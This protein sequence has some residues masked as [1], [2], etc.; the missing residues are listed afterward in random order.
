[1]DCAQPSCR[2]EVWQPCCRDRDERSRLRRRISRASLCRNERCGESVAFVGQLAVI[3]SEGVQEGRVPVIMMPR[4][5]DGFVAEFIR[6]AVD[7][8]GLEPAAGDPL[9]EAEATPIP[10][11]T[12]RKACVPGSL[13][14]PRPRA[15]R[16]SP[17]A[18][19]P[20]VVARA[21][22]SRSGCGGGWGR[23]GVGQRNGGRGIRDS[24]PSLD[25]RVRSQGACHFSRVSRTRTPAGYRSLLDWSR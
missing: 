15:G 7:M 12:G 23:L 25:S 16:P 19:P 2:F 6:L 20:R 24:L 11:R 1:M 10:P 3:A 8:P 18:R 5:N 22:L 9:A 14:H 4:I 17:P 21:R 13:A